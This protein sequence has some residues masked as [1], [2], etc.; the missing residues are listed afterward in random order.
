M[1]EPITKRKLPS[2]KYAEWT[3]RAG[4]VVLLFINLWL[5]DNFVTKVQYDI[6][7]KEATEAIRTMSTLLTTMQER[8]KVNDRQ[9][10][11]LADHE[12][13]IRILEKRRTQ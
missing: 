4:V 6:D 3:W 1:N 10:L 12:N 11:V 7:H 9:D 13:R 2:E 8:D 5:K